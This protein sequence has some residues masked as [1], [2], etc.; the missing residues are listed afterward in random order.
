LYRDQEY[1]RVAG[2]YNPDNPDKKQHVIVGTTDGKVTELYWGQTGGVSSGQLTQFSANSIV[3]IAGYYSDDDQMQ[4]VV[5]AINDGNVC[6]LV[7]KRGQRVQQRV[8]PKFNGIVGVAGYHIVSE[9]KHVLVGTSD[10]IV[11]ETFF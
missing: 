7:W 10:G 11:T 6:E 9:H 2:Y 3:E 4:H 8:L 5:V 1:V